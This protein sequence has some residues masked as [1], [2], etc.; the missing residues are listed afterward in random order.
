MS[1]KREEV[2]INAHPLQ[3]QRLGKQPTQDVLL[4]AAR[5]P[6][7]RGREIGSRQRTPV[8]LA[9]GGERQL[10]QHHKRRRNHVVG[11]AVRKMRAQPR[12]IG[13]LTRRR[14]H[15]GHQ[16]L[17]ARHILARNHRRLHHRRM[18]QQRR[19]DLARLNAEAADLDLLIG[20]PK[21]I[22]NPVRTPARQIPGA[23]HPAPRRTKPIG[24]KPLRRQTRTVQIASRKTCPRNVKLPRNPDR[25]RLKPA[26]QHIG[27]RVPDRTPNGERPGKFIRV[28]GGECSAKRGRFGRT[29]GVNQPATTHRCQDIADLGIRNDISPHEQLLDAGEAWIIIRRQGVEQRRTDLQQR[30]LVQLKLALQVGQGPLAAWHEHQFCSAEKRSPDLEGRGIERDW[31]VVDGRLLPRPRRGRLV[32]ADD[33]A[34]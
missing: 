18:A 34:M 24:H 12:R 15:I 26:V 7:Q 19:L 21:K 14:N 3:P 25:N 32:K 13:T 28:I 30:D 1:P 6:P 31:S 9:V 29:I 23:V 27:P 8:E 16:P 11:K 17:V 22:Q 2:V 4:R 20:P 5:R 10:R 33:T